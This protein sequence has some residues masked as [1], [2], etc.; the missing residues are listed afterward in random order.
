[1]W[2]PLSAFL[3][4]AP[5]SPATP[6]MGAI[7]SENRK[8]K[9]GNRLLDAIFYLRQGLSNKVFNIYAFSK[10]TVSKKLNII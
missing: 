7:V 4:F 3:E 8:V 2:W 6:S 1:M 5:A 10:G 9:A